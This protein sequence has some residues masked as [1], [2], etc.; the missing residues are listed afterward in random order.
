[1]AG[2][3]THSRTAINTNPPNE[4]AD[5]VTRQL[6]TALPN[7]LTQLVQ[8][9]GGNRANQREVT[10]SCSIKTFRASGAKEFFSTEGAVGLLTLFKSI[11]YVLYITKCPAE[12][13]VEFAARYFKKL[14][15]EEYCPDDKVQKLES[16]FWNHKMVVSD[17]DG[18]TNQG[19]N[20][21]QARGK[22][23]ALGVVEAPQDQNVVTVHGERPEGNMKQ[24]KTMKV[25]EP[26]LDD[27]PV[28]RDFPSVFPKD[29][30]GLPSPREVEFRIDLNPRV[31]PV[32]KSPYRNSNGDS[33]SSVALASAGAEGPIP[34]KI[35]EQKLA[36]KNKLKAKST[37]MLAIL[38]EHIL[39]F[40][41][42]KDAKSLWEAIKNRFGGN[43][44]SK[45]MQKTILK[46]NYKNFT[47]SSQ[48]RLDKT[49]DS[50]TN[51][52]VNTAHSVSAASSKDQA[53]TA[54]YD[55][56][57]M[58]SFFSN[59]SNA[60]QL[61]N[62]DLEQ[63]DAD[64]LEEIDLK[65]QVAML[66]MRVKRFIKKTGRKLDLNGKETVGFDR[67]K[68][69]CYNCHRRG[70]FAR[71]CRAPRNQGNKNRYDPRRNAPVDTSTTNALV[72]QDGIGGHD[73]SFQAEDGITNF[74]L[75]AYTSQGSSSLDSED[76]LFLSPGSEKDN[77][78]VPETETSISKTSKDIVEKPKTVRPSAPIIKEWDTNSDNDSVF[79]PKSD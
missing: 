3:N 7:L 44:E 54:S 71:E 79:R 9:L 5:E 67:T 41:A 65:W 22:A 8:A 56:D 78:K 25:N 16:E 35:A 59:Q 4:T 33:V 6:N 11:E 40:H 52:T 42:C 51:E 14:L 15:M 61:D 30:L 48:E 39:K 43:K 53:S 12:S 45:K 38:D 32:A 73:W 75:M 57:V 74:A 28:V 1:M 76:N 19:N 17:I 2:R 70:H 23:L 20:R 46:Q 24:L 62:E 37:L 55:D 18:N 13:Q 63:I 10:P 29:L 64:D 66:T 49:Y 36:R 21:N 72:V 31:M 26:K 77:H 68:V 34:P 50:S 60:P 47:T 58:F 69:E 27:I